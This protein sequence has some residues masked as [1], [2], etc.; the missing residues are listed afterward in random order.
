M[1]NAPNK[2]TPVSGAAVLIQLAGATVTTAVA[3]R[4][5]ARAAEDEYAAIVVAAYSAG[6]ALGCFLAPSTILRVGYVRAFD[7]ELTDHLALV[8]LPAS[9]QIV[10]FFPVPPGSFPPGSC[11]DNGYCNLP[12]LD[13][14][15]SVTVRARVD[16][17]SDAR[18]YILRNNA[19]VEADNASQVCSQPLA[20]A[21]GR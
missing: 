12:D 15:E 13:I 6:F 10:D 19:C 1:R 20:L 7:P 18:G 5:A 8:G 9:A 16:L 14:G 4:L 17:G 3:I 21:N 11:T 2:I